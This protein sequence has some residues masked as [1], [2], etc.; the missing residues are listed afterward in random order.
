MVP[1]PGPDGPTPVIA[2]A[3]GTTGVA[4]QTA[5]SLLDDPLA[6]GA[7][8]AVAEVVARGWAI[9]ATDYVGLGTAGP[10]AYLVGR[11]AGRAVLDAVRAAAAMDGPGPLGRVIA[12]GH[13]QGG[14]AA[15][16]TA[17]TAPAY[18][19]DVPLDGVVALSPAS[20]L[21]ALTSNAARIPV[22][23]IF[24]AYTIQGFAATY[25]DIV[26]EDWVRPACRHLVRVIAD[27]GIQGAE[28]IVAVVAAL[29]APSPI[30]SRD[31]T[32]GAMGAR[33]IEN[34]PSGRIG[35]PVLIGQGTGDPLIPADVQAVFVE[36]LRASGT[37]VDYR[38]Y[39]GLDHGG[40]VADGSP[41]V[42]EVLAWTAARFAAGR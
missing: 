17:L 6:Q 20:D 4:R 37:D 1:V 34:V 32:S 18:A 29:V 15:L 3:H 14:A 39:E 5:P 16:W 40:V 26:L 21:T 30:W 7:M 9:V 31:P 23:A 19:R 12:W 36:A 22:G 42:P 11:E 25:P 41:T 10:H 38:T 33:L 13:S 35:V 28:G 8:P 2:W 27:R 24:A